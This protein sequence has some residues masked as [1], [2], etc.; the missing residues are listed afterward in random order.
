MDYEDWESN[1]PNLSGQLTSID[2]RQGMRGGYSTVYKSQWNG[3]LVSFVFSDSNDLQRC[4][5]SQVA[6]KVLSA[7]KGTSLKSMRRKI[8]RE[9]WIWSTLDHPN[10]LPL[11]GFADDDPGFEPFGAFISP[12][13]Q[14]GNSEEY[15][16]LNGDTLNY[17]QRLTLWSGAICG[18]I[19]LHT[20]EP[21]IIHGDIKPTNILIDQHGSPK[22]CDFGLSRIYFS[23]GETGLTTSLYTGTERYLA[24]ELVELAE[25]ALPT[26]E[27]DVYAMGCVGLKFL[28]SRNAYH[29]RR[30]NVA[31]QIFRDI[32][33]GIP[34]ETFRDEVFVGCEQFTTI[35]RHTWKRV[36]STRPDMSGLLLWLQYAELEAEQDNGTQE[37]HD[38][39]IDQRIQSQSEADISA[40]QTIAPV[41]KKASKYE[42]TQM[43]AYSS[44]RLVEPKYAASGY[45]EQQWNINIEEDIFPVCL[46]NNRD[47][48]IDFGLQKFLDTKPAYWGPHYVYVGRQEAK[49]EI[50]FEGDST[51]FETL[52]SPASKL[53]LARLPFKVYREDAKFIREVVDAA[54]YFDLVL[55]LTPAIRAFRDNVQMELIQVRDSGR[56]QGG[57]RIC[58]GTGF[59]FSKNQDAI[60]RAPKGLYCLKLVNNS[61]CSLYPYLF[62]LNPS[63]FGI[64]AY[65]QSSESSQFMGIPPGGVITIADNVGNPWEH[66]VAGADIINVKN[67]VPWEHRV[68]GV[69]DINIKNVVGIVQERQGLDITFLKLFLT[70][71]PMDFSF[72]PQ[73]SPFRPYLPGVDSGDLPQTVFDRRKDN[74]DTDIITIIT[75][76]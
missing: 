45:T 7:L 73:S 74:W 60:I 16:D 70:I 72:I 44:D 8:R 18:A 34:P 65:Y 39:G 38:Q 57:S 3:D 6:V 50:I 32:V 52:N 26:C 69:D 48:Y 43:G 41:L 71:K 5:A 76:S 75:T 25:K 64:E 4:I 56:R 40:H 12:W 1:I 58:E 67:N 33:E 68:A 36:P 30:N 9:R 20:R 35:L 62:R 59:N 21:P 31:G 27:S 15:L 29:H 19:Y 51:Q 49:L 47:S 2:F 11:L 66:R 22:L 55:Q 42:V 54:A 13:C 17:E 53:G 23:E 24:P 28:F 10:I 63:D 14:Y 46:T 37:P 61:P